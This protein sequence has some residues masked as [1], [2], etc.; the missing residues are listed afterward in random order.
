MKSTVWLIGNQSNFNFSESVA[1]TGD[2]LTK[3]I[4]IYIHMISL[5]YSEVLS[6]NFYK[7]IVTVVHILDWH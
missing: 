3:T 2:H 5:L 7:T 6:V 4:N 1:P